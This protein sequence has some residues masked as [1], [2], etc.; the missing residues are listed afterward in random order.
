MTTSQSGG[1][2]A[3]AARNDLTV[4]NAAREVFFEQGYDAPMS[5]IAE[6][7]GVG[8]GS[9]YRRYRSKEELA[10]C[11]CVLSMKG[12]NESA[13]RAL[14]E[15]SSGWSALVRFM[16]ESIDR[17][18]GMVA[19]FAGEFPVTPEMVALSERG[20]A[21]MQAILDRAT[22]EGSVRPD[23]TAGDLVYLLQILRTNSAPTPT[24]VTT[25][26]T[27]YLT[28]LLDGL[29]PHPTPTPLPGPAP[30]WPE[31]STRWTQTP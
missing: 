19:Q 1:R 9:L 21:A 18:V 20:A 14:A 8:M 17:G 2:K 5:A 7:A 22:A 31:I 16:A 4:L 10:R 6:R 13:E 24:R 15:E 27:R 12:T 26:R 25:L 3:E 29:R 11:L 28:L 30:T 23:I